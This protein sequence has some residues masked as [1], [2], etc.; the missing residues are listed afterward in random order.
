MT[1][2]LVATVGILGIALTACGGGGSNNSGAASQSSTGSGS[3][4]QTAQQAQPLGAQQTYIGTVSFGDTI[5]VQ[6]DAPSKGQVTTTFINSQFGLAG[7]LVGSYTLTNGNYVV[8]DFQA[9]GTVPAALSA[10]ANAMGL[11]FTIAADS[12]NHGILNGQL[13]NV[14]NVTAGS[15]SQTLSGQVAASNNGVTTVAGLA[16]TYSFIKLSGDYTSAGVP[17]GSQ[18]ADSGQFQI[19]ADGSFRA[20]PSSAYTAS[21]MDDSNANVADTGTITVD[22]DQTTYPGAFDVTMN[23]SSFGRLFVSTSAGKNTL[24]LD[25]AGLNSDGT[26]R[27]GSLVFQTAQPL[28]SGAYDGTWLC[29]EPNTT[30]KNQLLGD[31]ISKSVAIAGATLTPSGQ[32]A[33]PMTLNFNATFNAAAS[34]TT[35]TYANGV[36]GL[37]AGL[38]SNTSNGATVQSAMMFLPVSPTNIYYLDEVNG[39]GFF[40]EGLCV[41]Q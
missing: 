10:G 1:I 26:F 13:S 41:K 37:M 33:A 12:S 16:G 3:G 2:R 4:S 38:L 25:Q 21:C 15:G 5:S 11:Q 27:T 40:V 24:I 14:P 7:K 20:C 34:S 18:D 39:N 6:I 23:G 8:S 22:P 35:P 17:V 30:D 32:G 28:T 36:N 29:S 31:I 19:N 9:S